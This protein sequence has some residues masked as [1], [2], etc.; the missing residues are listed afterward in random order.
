MNAL[1][2]IAT[3]D[4]RQL[5]RDR[6]GLFM[7]LGFPAL[8]ALFFGSIF[9]SGGGARGAMRVAF[10]V[11]EESALARRFGALLEADPS[12][13]LYEAALDVATDDVRR[14]R[15]V[16][17]V[18]IREGFADGYGVFNE[19]GV[20]VAIDP[21]R[22][23]EAGFL[24]GV[25]IRS[26]MQAL[27]EAFVDLP[28]ALDEVRRQ[29]VRVTEYEDLGPVERQLLG[30]WLSSVESLITLA[31]DLDVADD[32]AGDDAKDGTRDD[33]SNPASSTG[34]GGDSTSFELGFKIEPL[35]RDST[36][37]PRSGYD[38]TFPSSIMW[39]V[40]GCVS[41]F[42]LSIVIERRRGTYQR[43][44]MAP[45]PSSTILLGKGLA[46]LL[47]TL[48]TITILM[49]FGVVVFGVRIGSWPLLLVA[50]VAT[51]L[52]FVGAMMLVAVLG[53]TEASVGGAGWA[54]F[55][56]W[57]MLG[58]GM[59]PLIAMPAW[60][61]PAS[62]ASPVKWGVLAIEGAVWRD[63]TAAQMVLPVGILLGVGIVTY[64]IGW[65]ILRARDRAGQ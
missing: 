43:L 16:A 13:R 61:V 1:L 32:T 51:A 28:F 25:L 15:A 45:I 27:Q 35:A 21:S 62:H 14:G 19:E 10:V 49:T 37:Q 20:V 22:Q 63:F 47:A 26:L 17:L 57:M 59:I 11:E 30:A 31:I 42:S 2:A 38:I 36:G 12:V 52:C 55:L 53:K 3:K 39:G 56:V 58:G 23:A 6:F 29:R 54:L 8:M 34:T 5:A 50:A 64:A 40:V 46:C 33:A 60:M 44:R 41:A 7:V 18:R 65:S 9:S 24:Q 4:L 48:A